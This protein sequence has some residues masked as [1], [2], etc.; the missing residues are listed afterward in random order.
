MA[1]LISTHA[2]YITGLAHTYPQYSLGAQEFNDLIVRLYPDHHKNLGYIQ[3][4]SMLYHY[5]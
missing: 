1:H 3:I 2:L 5:F 4:F